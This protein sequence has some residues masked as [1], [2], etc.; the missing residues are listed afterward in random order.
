MAHGSLTLEVY[1]RLPVIRILRDRTEKPPKRLE[2]ECIASCLGYLVALEQKVAL[3]EA[4]CG[5][6]RLEVFLSDER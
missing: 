6:M 2:K 3:E 4:F 1:H 5:W